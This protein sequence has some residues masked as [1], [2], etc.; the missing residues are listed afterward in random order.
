MAVNV[1]RRGNKS[2]DSLREL[3]QLGTILMNQYSSHEDVTSRL[4]SSGA[5]VLSSSLLL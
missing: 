3:M 2:F 1:L 4:L 5:G